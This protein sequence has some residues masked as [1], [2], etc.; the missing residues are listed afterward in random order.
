MTNL[1]LILKLKHWHLFASLLVASILGAFFDFSEPAGRIANDL[2]F[3]SLMIWFIVVSISLKQKIGPKSTVLFIWSL[4]CALTSIAGRVALHWMYNLDELF[5]L[6]ED[7][8]LRYSIGVLAI[9]LFFNLTIFPAKALR[10]LENGDNV[11]LDEMLGDIVR[12]MFWPLGIWSIQPR[13][14]K[15]EP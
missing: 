13:L 2:G 15:L 6:F 1:N 7:K 14:N 11:T 3:L 4:F 5:L 10:T 8:F 12:L 9:F